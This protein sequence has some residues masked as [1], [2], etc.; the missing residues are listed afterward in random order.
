MRFF[1]VLSLFAILGSV[2]CSRSETLEQEA[3]TVASN[4][5]ADRVPDRVV[6]ARNLRRVGKPIAIPE[7]EGRPN[8]LLISLDNVR[9]D[10]MSS[11]GNPR[12]TTPNLD[13]LAKRGTRFADCTSQAPFTPHSYSSLFSSLH[14][15]DLPVRE[16]A[17]G[18]NEPVVR[19]GLEEY[20]LTLPEVMQD[21]GYHTAAILRG[22]FTPAF[23]LT[24]GYDRVIYKNQPTS[25]MV[26]D[27][28]RWL[29]A[30]KEKA[31]DRPFF[32]FAYA[33]DVHY[34]FMDR[35]PASSHVFGGNPE[36]FNIDRTVLEPYNKG[37]LKP[38]PA[39][40]ENALTLYDEGLY[41]ADREIKPLLDE[42][43]AL[44]VD[45]S[46]IV[47]FASDHG[48]EF[49]EHGYLSHG[50]S[51]FRTVVHVPLII[52]DPRVRRGRTIEEPVM[53]IDLMPTIL[54]L[55]RIPV[56][57]TAKGT[58]LANLV[59]G[60]N[61]PTLEQRYIFSEG[62]WN[63][64]IGLARAG[65]WAFLMDKKRTPY[66]FDYQEDPQEKRNLAGDLPA[67]ARHLE[68]VLFAHKREGLG[69]QLTHLHG[70][71]LELDRMALPVLDP[72]KLGL[73][74]AEVEPQLDEE[75]IEQ[76]R[77]LGYLQ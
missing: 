64:F 46:T 9:A 30:W 26:D 68:R 31:S 7:V 23:G 24:Q 48:E 77:A 58:S 47:V 72:S 37:R 16:R 22:W 54:E 34:R 19:A 74:A 70:L 75:S 21:A 32:L 61:L 53:N 56:P 20:H 12:Q 18:S 42:L 1:F 43:K 65:R 67:L 6:G 73:R 39:E 8:V 44:G 71:S 66:L 25:G 49:T 57:E 69:T 4:N 5:G 14:V 41:W 60:S 50:Q 62:S 59:R 55:C 27:S 51:N 15:S 52:H 2:G 76:L 45:D 40:L 36:G 38:T 3:P 63:G 29:R 13:S 33:V 10:R 35:R 11:Y 28:I 17:R